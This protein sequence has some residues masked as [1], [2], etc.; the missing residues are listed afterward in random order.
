ML[1]RYYRLR[2]L[3]DN[4]T[5]IGKTKKTIGARLKTHHDNL[6]KYLNGKNRKCGSYAIIQ[7]KVE[8]VDYIIELIFEL[9]V[10]QEPTERVIEQILINNE[11]II[12][13]DGCCN[14]RDAYTSQDTN[15][16]EYR[17]YKKEYMRAYRAKLAEKRR[18]V[19]STHSKPGFR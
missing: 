14:V 15:N 1:Y 7:Y 2:S 5:Y 13:P 18:L 12:N 4:K 6:K 19:K 16:D 10:D 17:K 9:D 11:R 3:I 8:N